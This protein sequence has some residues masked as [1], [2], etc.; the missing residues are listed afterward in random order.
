MRRL[1]IEVLKLAM[2]GSG[3]ALIWHGIGLF[4]KYFAAG[5]DSPDGIFRVMANNHGVYRYITDAQDDEYRFFLKVG[6]AL[7]LVMFAMILAKLKKD[8]RLRGDGSQ[9]AR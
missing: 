7:S 2:A 5:K 9:E 3:P 4:G 8:R 1:F 6:A